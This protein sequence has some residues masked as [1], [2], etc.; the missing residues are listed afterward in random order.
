MLLLLISAALPPVFSGTRLQPWDAG[1]AGALRR[2][3][4]NPAMA[5]HLSTLQSLSLG[6]G[7]SQTILGICPLL[8]PHLIQNYPFLYNLIS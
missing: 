8:Y 3:A 7:L 2:N 6:Q 1:N 4:T 5:V